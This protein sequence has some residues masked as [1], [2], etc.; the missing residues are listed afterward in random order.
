MQ[1]ELTTNDINAAQAQ[2]VLR[3][4]IPPTLPRRHREPQSALNPQ[5]RGAA[6]DRRPTPW[7]RECTRATSSSVYTRLKNGVAPVST[8]SKRQSRGRHVGGGK[9]C[10]FSSFSSF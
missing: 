6:A 10:G 8:G 5:R 1:I 2:T 7:R 9:T 4:Y 3:H